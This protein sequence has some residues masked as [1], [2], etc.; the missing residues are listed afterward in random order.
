MY[1]VFFILVADPLQAADASQ[2]PLAS[3]MFVYGMYI[4]TDQVIM[5]FYQVFMW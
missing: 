1:A 2:P 3:L 4:S 5:F